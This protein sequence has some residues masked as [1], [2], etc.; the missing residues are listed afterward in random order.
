MG[1]TTRTGALLGLL[2]ALVTLCA[3]P[4]A[5]ADGVPTAKSAGRAFALQSKAAG[6]KAGAP[7]CVS[8]ETEAP[9]DRYAQLRAGT[10]CTDVSGLGASET[11]TLHTDDKGAHVALRSEAD[12]RYVSAEFHYTG[13]RFG[14][15]RARQ[16]GSIGGWERFR[17]VDLGDGWYALKAT[18]TESGVSTDYYVSAEV[19]S[20][21][22][23]EGL[24]RAR[25]PAAGT[26]GSWERFRLVELPAAPRQPP[27]ASST[28]ARS[29]HALT[30]NTCSNNAG[31][32]PTMYGS[33]VD[34]FTS[35][36]ARR[37]VAAQAD[38]V[39]LEEFC[40]KLA[41]P[42]ER[43]LE[44]ALDGGA[45]TW[46]VRFAP[47][48]Y[49]VAGTGQWARKECGGN[50]G[51]YGVAVAVPAEN[52]WYRAVELD[53]P[54]GR[55]R[56]T[57]LCAAVPSWAV[58]A[59]AAHFS[60]GGAGYDDPGR[61]VQRQQARDL[62]AQLAGYSGYRPVFGGD[63]NATPTAVPEDGGSPVVQPLYDAYGEC[64]RP[65]DRPT[66]GPAKLDY[67]FAPTAA[68][69]SGCTVGSDPAG[70]SDHQP[71]WGTVNLP[72]R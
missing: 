67:L 40:E 71:L 39:F 64:D 3:A 5:Q 14:T 6:D 70:L 9:D 8:V 11:F 59:C 43:K 50:R 4:S 46:D 36:V 2:L 57:A 38:V 34:D 72:A 13:S 19:G 23:D 7:V 52:T 20:T 48:Q 17:P 41:K 53:S 68:T 61:T 35:A 66:K 49:Q 30:W 25:T 51:S 47:I 29:I 31:D 12:G 32:C 16:D 45:D 28:P 44:A 33:P 42:L 18:L 22:E 37:A 62:A 55:E 58:M 21:G 65:A 24:L 26:P 1:R 69:W 10:D 63:L 54:T 15:L 56:R 27:A 60:T